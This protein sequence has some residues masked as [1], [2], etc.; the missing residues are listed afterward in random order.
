MRVGIMQ[1]TLS[2]CLPSLSFVHLAHHPPAEETAPLVLLAP[3]CAM[4]I[5]KYACLGYLYPCNYVDTGST[6]GTRISSFAAA[7]AAAAVHTSVADVALSAM[8]RC[9][10]SANST[11][12]QRL[13]GDDRPV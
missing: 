7:A 5:R 8:S 6:Y 1:W 12:L 13:H 10:A 9:S 3:D 2:A 4:Q 11:V